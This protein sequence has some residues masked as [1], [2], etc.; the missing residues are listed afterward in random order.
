MD[1]REQQVFR[2]PMVLKERKA[3]K[4]TRELMGYKVTKVQR[5]HRV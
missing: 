4:E 3:S 1:H 5:V 2:V